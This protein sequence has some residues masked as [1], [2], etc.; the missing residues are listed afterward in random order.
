MLNEDMEYDIVREA[1]EDQPRQSSH[2]QF[3]HLVN[4]Q[5][6]LSDENKHLVDRVEMLHSE[7]VEMADKISIL[8]TNLKSVH[9][10]LNKEKKFPDNQDDH[11]ASDNCTDITPLRSVLPGC[12]HFPHDD[13]VDVGG[14]Y[15]DIRGH[16]VVWQLGMQT[17]DG[18]TNLHAT[19][20]ESISPKETTLSN[21]YTRMKRQPRKRVKSVACRTPFMSRVF[22]KKA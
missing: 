20:Q 17:E 16:N 8:E 15:C 10:I 9:D 18:V 5:K 12:S 3:E 14:A 7:N 4:E 2:S 11:C 19:L 22:M 6:R 13:S 21:M 1:M